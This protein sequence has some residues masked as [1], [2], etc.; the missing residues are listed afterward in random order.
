MLA[1]RR[2]AWQGFLPRRAILMVRKR[3][4]APCQS[5]PSPKVIFLGERLNEPSF[6]DLLERMIHAMG[7]SLDQVGIADPSALKGFPQMIVALG[8]GSA[9]NLLATEES[10]AS[11]R[12]RFHVLEGGTRVRVIHHPSELMNNP[13]AKRE[14]WS[15]L[16][17]VARELGIVIPKK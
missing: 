4:L 12:G 7:L 10:L 13:S 16:Q 2:A 3:D 11:L 14:A 1:N 6:R 5:K 8:E 15:D 17:Q 9:Q